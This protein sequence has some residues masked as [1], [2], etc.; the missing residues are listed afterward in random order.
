MHI[1]YLELPATDLQAQR[2]FYAHEL[3]LPAAL[4]TAR[5]EVQAGETTLVFT[6]ADSGFDGAYHFAFN[7]P[8]NRFRA[9]KEWIGQRLPVLRNA[10]GRD[11]YDFDN[12]RAHAFYFKDAAGNILEFI[13]R[14][15]LP[16]AVDGPFDGRQILCV[17]EIGLPSED[18]IAFADD[19]CTQ[20]ELSVF[21]GAPDAA[22]TAIGD[23]HGLFILP[24]K[25]RIWMPDSG[26]YARLL[27]VYVRGEVNAKRWE[28]RGVPYQITILV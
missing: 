27:P 28:V 7:I 22:F 13:A 12:W 6:Q 24:I 21:R 25:N 16:N 14:H 17:S 10:E 5:L 2:D 20:L 3:E 9:A 1:R 19:L 8:E 26:V 11:E 4:S 15:D 18:V 23:N